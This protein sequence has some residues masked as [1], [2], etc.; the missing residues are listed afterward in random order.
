MAVIEL[1][2]KVD[3]DAAPTGRLTL[4]F[5]AR[6][7]SRLRAKLDDGTDV[8]VILPRGSQLLPGDRLA[9]ADGMVVEVRAASEKVSRVS[10]D[11]VHLL[12]R[13]CYH[14][15]NRHVALQIL[16]SESRRD[17]ISAVSR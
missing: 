13:A 10:T 1:T 8:A 4:D 14:L 5:E 15:G 17:S 16:P 2:Q 11:D 9:S 12:T 6:S 7:K 3:A